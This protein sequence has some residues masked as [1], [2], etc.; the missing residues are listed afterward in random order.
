MKRL[1]ILSVF[2]CMAA[3][4]TGQDPVKS[5]PKVYHVVVDNARVRVLRVSVGPGAK[6]TMHEHPDNVT[7]ALTSSKVRFTDADGKSQDADLKA[8]EA[9]WNGPQKHMG[10][11]TGSGPV[12]AL[13]IELK[14]SAPATATTVPSER[15][16]LKGTKL[17]ENARADV[18]RATPDASFAEP[19]GTTHP[20]DTVVIA[21]APSDTRVTIEGKTK[22]K[23]QRGDVVF[24][25]RNTAHESKAGQKP[26]EILLVAIK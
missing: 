3:P 5:N 2:L 10:E 18:I 11:N 8:D 4:A 19:A 13:V 20:W 12:D 22:D 21:L 7:V 26:G 25:G 9:I 15:P 1:L 24:I 16:G 23:W 14:G 17:I 6:T